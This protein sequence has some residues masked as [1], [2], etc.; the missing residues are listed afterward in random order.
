MEDNRAADDGVGAGL[1]GQ[2][3]RRDVEVAGAVRADL[4]VAEVTRV[5]LHVHGSG[6]GHAARVE[7]PAG[8]DRLRVRAIPLLVDVETVGAR[9]GLFDVDVDLDAAGR[10]LGERRGARGGRVAPRLD[11]RPGPG[12]LGGGRRGRG[13]PGQGEGGRGRERQC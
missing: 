5:T 7:V 12:T 1:D 4:D 2:H 3:V 8:G 13:A 9:R 10:E 11:G 6:V